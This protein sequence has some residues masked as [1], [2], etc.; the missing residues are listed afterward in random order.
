[1]QSQSILLE[2]TICAKNTSEKQKVCR[3]GRGILCL[4]KRT[5]KS[6]ET[7]KKLNQKAKIC[8]YFPLEF[9]TCSNGHN[10]KSST[11]FF[12][13]KAC[14]ILN[15]QEKCFRTD[16]TSVYF[17]INSMASRSLQ[18]SDSVR[19][20]NLSDKK[21]SCLIELPLLDKDHLFVVSI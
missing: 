5:S 12:Q 1:M 6:L 9:L 17:P 4:R 19:A 18:N 7:K 2:P 11:F 13:L 14:R 15:P 20:T 21:I 8:I 10:Y 16:A 3:V